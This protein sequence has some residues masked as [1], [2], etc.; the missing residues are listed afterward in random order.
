MKTLGLLLWLSSGLVGVA[1]AQPDV[2]REEGGL[3]ERSFFVVDKSGAPVFG[4]RD[5]ATAEPGREA[6]LGDFLFA[7]EETETRVLVAHYPPVQEVGWMNKSDLLL[8]QRTHALTVSEGV[9]RGLLRDVVP[10]DLDGALNSNNVLFLRVVTQPERR[11]TLS[12]RPGEGAK[13][14]ERL[15]TWRWF[16]AY[17]LETFDGRTWVLLGDR[18]RMLAGRVFEH[19]REGGPRRVLRGWVPLEHVTVWATNLALELDTD[20]LAIDRRLRDADP[21]V[22]YASPHSQSLVRWTEPMNS[23]WPAGSPHP[24]VRTD[25]AGLDPYYPRAALLARAPGRLQAAFAASSGEYKISRFGWIREKVQAAEESVRRVDVVFVIDATGSMNDAIDPT[26]DLVRD[27]G[28]ALEEFLAEGRSTTLDLPGGGT[29]ELS[30]A[31][32]IRVSVIGFQDT[33]AVAARRGTYNVRPAVVGAHLVEDAADIENALSSLKRD[34]TGSAGAEALHDALREAMKPE[35]WRPNSYTRQVI[36]MTDEQGDT[37]DLQQLVAEMPVFTDEMLQISPPLRQQ[38]GSDPL[39]NKKLRTRLFSV[40]LGPEAE[41]APFRKNVESVSTEMFRLTDFE[42]GSRGDVVVDAISE[43]LENAQESVGGTVRAY[44]KGL[45]DREPG[46][47][48]TF[49]APDGISDLTIAMALIMQGLSADEI[50]QLN[51]TVYVEGFVREANVALPPAGQ[52]EG[53]PHWRLR[54]LVSKNDAREMYKTL[55][56]ASRGLERSL[57]RNPM[58]RDLVGQRDPA[59]SRRELVA[60]V[61]V[62]A[63]DEITDGVD[64]GFTDDGDGDGDR[65]ALRTAQSLLDEIDGGSGPDGENIALRAGLRGSLPIRSDGLLGLPLAELVDKDI[66]WFAIQKDRLEEQ[67]AGWDNILD[68]YSVPENPAEFFAHIGLPKLWF[69][70]IDSV[71]GNDVAHVPFSYIP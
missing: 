34:T 63:L 2:L 27:V 60:A 69:M 65:D 42:G 51:A 19:T 61:I 21:A 43:A 62:R 58:L 5:A 33:K 55:S 32:D 39:N 57:D 6:T 16:Y 38:V 13:A 46:S 9:G 25:P 17:D 10:V 44:W 14:D 40:F 18:R 52:S 68:G 26:M 64:Y 50:D 12:C 48:L 15:V 20:P 22:I 23:F 30:E 59:V 28:G 67:S 31:M 41:W 54:V 36:L 53:T 24:E 70:Q 8:E 49:S 56:G 66:A 45:I 3:E 4:T 37:D 29:L 11:V 71:R 35:Y 1:S 47:A 7:L